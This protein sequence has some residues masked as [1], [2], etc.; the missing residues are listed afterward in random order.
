MANKEKHKKNRDLEWLEAEE[1]TVPT[2]SRSPHLLGAY[3]KIPKPVSKKFRA[4]S[5]KENQAPPKPDVSL[6][7]EPGPPPKLS[8]KPSQ[9]APREHQPKQ[10]R[11]PKLRAPYQYKNR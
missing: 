10:E 8:S 7:R 6:A 1:S 3:I 5:P 11:L 4:N 9:A 2:K